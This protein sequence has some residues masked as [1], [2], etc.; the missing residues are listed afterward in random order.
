LVCRDGSGATNGEGPG[1]IEVRL[2]RRR[3]ITLG[4]DTVLV[5]GNL[6][7]CGGAG[8]TGGASIPV[9]LEV[10]P[11]RLAALLGCLEAE[12]LMLAE[13]KLLMLAE[14]WRRS[15]AALLS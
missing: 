13:S 2:L 11:R 1:N 9:A 10:L 5:S 3:F 7:A 14:L 4:A 6:V 8:A 15:G 12:A